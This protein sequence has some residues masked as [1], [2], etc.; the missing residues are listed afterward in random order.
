MF[1]KLLS[2]GVICAVTFTSL[3]SYAQEDKEALKKEI[4]KKVEERLKAEREKTLEK[5][6]QL[7]DEK[8]SGESLSADKVKERMKELDREIEK[9][10]AEKEKLAKTLGKHKQEKNEEDNEDKEDNNKKDEEGELT[11]EEA[12]KL[13]QECYALHGEKKYEE[14]IS[15]FKKIFDQFPKHNWGFT[16]AYNVSCAYALLGEKE[17]ALDWLEKSVENGFNQFDHMEEDPDLDSL[18]D[19]PRYKKIIENS[20]EEGGEEE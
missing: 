15:G 5:I 14:A 8:L 18:R 2:A 7:I 12:G 20:G 11:L 13:F 19:E 4:L 10:K 9:L 1:K 17:K 16:S 6:E 3:L